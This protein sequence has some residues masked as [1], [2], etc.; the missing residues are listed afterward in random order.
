MATANIDTLLGLMGSDQ[1]GDP[2]DPDPILKVR[3]NRSTNV[4]RI[5]VYDG[6]KRPR[7]PPLF[8]KRV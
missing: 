5:F 2:A 4:K 1:V 7:A 6:S 8:S 3:Y